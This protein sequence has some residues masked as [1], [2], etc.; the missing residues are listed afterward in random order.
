VETSVFFEDAEEV[1]MV[2]PPGEIGV[3]V[4]ESEEDEEALE[5][6]DA[7][8]GD[9]DFLLPLALRLEVVIFRARRLAAWFSLRRTRS[10]SSL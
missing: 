9:L 4:R 1:V 7:G 3:V 5:E 8:G 2:I 6:A 10:N